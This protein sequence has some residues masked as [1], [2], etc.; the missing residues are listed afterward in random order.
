MPRCP[1][2]A[3]RVS[4]PMPP[5]T[6]STERTGDITL[7]SRRQNARRPGGTGTAARFERKPFA[8]DGIFRQQIF[9]ICGIVKWSAGTLRRHDQSF[10]RLLASYLGRGRPAA[11]GPLRLVGDSLTSAVMNFAY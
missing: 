9:L 4:P 3:A 1:N 6:I 7:I 2:A 8:A 5:P 11:R 10:N